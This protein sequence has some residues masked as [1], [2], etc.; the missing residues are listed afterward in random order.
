[1]N[2]E[3]YKSKSIFITGHT[4]FK[5]SW[6][7]RILQLVGAN[8]T[9]Y[10][11]AP[12]SGGAYRDIVDESA[13][14]SHIGD[15]RDYAALSAAFEEAKPEIVFHLAAQPLVLDSYEQP[16]YTFDTNVMGTVNLL[17]AVRHHGTVRSVVVVTTD[18]VYRNNEWVYGYRENDTLG[19][20]DPYSVSKA[21]AELV[22]G[23]YGDAFLR[24]KGV[25]LSTVRAG[26][27]IGGGDNAANRI[28]PDC[29][30]AAA[31]GK[32]IIVRNPKSIRPYQHILE[33]LFAYLT[34][35]QK[36]F[37]SPDF[38]GSYNIGPKDMDCVTTD[39]LVR[40]FCEVWG[41]G[42]AYENVITANAPHESGLLKLDCSKMLAVFGWRPLW[43]I[44]T[45]IAKTVE[46]AK[47]D[48]KR[49]ITDR[50]ISEYAEAF[51]R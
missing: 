48:D 43:N 29:I 12:V 11:L 45:A 4:G 40:I 1:M 13:I 51:E 7:C 35:A 42:Q 22:A 15:V 36:Q 5:G 17:E 19:G 6:L 37:E 38:A 25:A 46:W 10:A 32:P 24:Q 33:P 2:L 18:K 26:N 8:I 34:I 9:G 47:S 16:A 20:N 23:I 44:H 21:C 14:T 50:Q 3:F 49:I 27:V 41:D 30:R 28:I 39:E 31:V